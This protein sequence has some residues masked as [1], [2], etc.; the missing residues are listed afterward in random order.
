VVILVAPTEHDL[1]RHFQS[2]SIRHTVS[3]LPERHGC[4]IL[5]TTTTG[6]VG[7]Q[8]K[9]LPDLQASLLDGR[10]YQELAQLN[11]SASVSLAFLVIESLLART[12]EGELLGDSSTITIDQLRSI[13]AKF[14]AF[15]VGHFQTTSIPDTARAIVSV[16]R[17]A[18]SGDI[19]HLRRPKQLRN[20]WGLIT[21]ESYALWL[22]QSFP[23]VGPKLA[24]TIFEHLGSQVPIRWTVTEK[25][26]MEVPGI[27]KKMARQLLAALGND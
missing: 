26:L 3:S 22:L 12:T 19:F 5:C 1:Q 9:T 8:R 25:E 27:G 10:L 16:G 2:R 24:K 15:G 17:Y 21:D 7:F 13:I 4:D 23:G 6:L 11:A 18:S 14:A 20:E